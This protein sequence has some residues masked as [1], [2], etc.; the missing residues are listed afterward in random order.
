MGRRIVIVGGVAGG[1]S[2]AARARR[3]DEHAEIVV[4]E[5]SGYIS[6]ANCG[7]PYFVAG[8]IV[9]K[10]KLLVTTPEAVAGRFAIDARV[11]SEVVG[12]DR[13]RKVVRVK[14]LA[15]GTEYELGYDKLIL[16]V[17]AVP[18][19]PKVDFLGAKNV[20]V[21]RSIEDTARVDEYIR[22]IPPGTRAVVVGAGFIGLEMVEALVERG[23]KVTL[24]EKNGTVL[25]PLDAEMSGPLREVLE[26]HGAE[27]ITGSG[28]AQMHGE[29]ALARE[30]E[31]EDGRRIAAGLVLLSV[32][33]RPNVGLAQQAGLK[34]GVTG[35]IEVD[36][37]GRTSDVDVYA[38]GDAVEVRHGVSGRVVRIPLA[39][40]ANKQGRTVGEHA[41]TG[42]AAPVGKTLGTAI[43]QVFEAAG[44]LTGLSEKAARE[45]GYEVGV[46]YASGAHHAS[47]YPGATP[48]RL[49][50]VYDVPTGKVLGAQ[51][52]GIEGVDKRIDVIATAISFGGTVDDLANLDL[53]YAPQFGSAKD[54]VHQVAYVAQNQRREI[55]A[56]VHPRDVNGRAMV[57]V[58]SA[59]E[60]AAGHWPGSINI[61]VEELRGRLAEVADGAAVYCQIGQRG[62]LAQRILKQRGKKDVVNVK[63][64]W[65]LMTSQR[66]G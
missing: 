31:L 64:G 65:G 13:G 19:L 46:A 36:E 4:L 62:Y 28:I 41:V 15:G 43:V 40:P 60:F 14:D 32:G 35:A 5:K 34:I 61:P 50:L 24:V 45:A 27:V 21:L 66:P 22:S 33:V 12:I 3:M 1:M 26:K 9:G 58:R 48:M 7:L 52:V 37:V 51:V 49:K 55:M 56:A 25:P 16:A 57:D 53:A 44:G 47:Y 30:V 11:K 39:G 8:R 59:K 23:M 38:V 2:A 63:G 17:G 10:E 18:I 29:G 54:P 20:F 42:K 6:Y